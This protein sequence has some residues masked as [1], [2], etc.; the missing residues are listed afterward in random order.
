MTNLPRRSRRLPFLLAL[1]IAAGLLAWL[2]WPRPQGSADPGLPT[3]LRWGA[4]AAGGAPYIFGPPNQRT[5]FEV[6]LADYF[7]EQLGLP[8][9]FVQGDWDEIPEA[10]LRGNVDVALNGY[11]FLP[12]R[13]KRLPSTIPY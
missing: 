12:E 7:G 13:E 8:T 9:E 6:E 3:V 4:D 10:L 11:E 2:F 1:V 5:G